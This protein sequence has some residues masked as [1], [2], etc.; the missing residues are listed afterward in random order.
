MF[1]VLLYGAPHKNSLFL[2]LKQVLYLYVAEP[3][4]HVMEKIVYDRPEAT[5]FSCLLFLKL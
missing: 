5:V 2:C 4:G 3:I 1:S